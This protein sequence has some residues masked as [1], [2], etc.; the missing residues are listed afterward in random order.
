MLAKKI[1]GI[2][3]KTIV[4]SAEALEFSGE[5]G[6]LLSMSASWHRTIEKNEK[7]DIAEFMFLLADG[8]KP[9]QVEVSYENGKFSKNV[10]DLTKDMGDVTDEEGFARKLKFLS[11]GDVLAIIEKDERVDTALKKA[12]HLRAYSMEFVIYDEDY[13][14]PVWHVLLK[15]RPL[16]NHFKRE[17]PLT[18]DVVVEATRGKIVTLAIHLA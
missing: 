4:A 18:I 2:L 12:R 6:I 14:A 16:T 3:A 7:V 1:E 8:G 5:N 9:V 13:Q 15:N 10:T 17:K 11:D